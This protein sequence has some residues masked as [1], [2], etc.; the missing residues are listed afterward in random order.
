VQVF[1]LE[2]AKLFFQ[3]LLFLSK[4]PRQPETAAAAVRTGMFKNASKKS[5]RLDKGAFAACSRGAI[6]SYN[7][8]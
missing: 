1:F 8:V 6:T 2:K 5:R 3:A 4:T 7:Y